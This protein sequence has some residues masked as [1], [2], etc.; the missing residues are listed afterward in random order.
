MK[1]RLAVILCVMLFAQCTT[2]RIQLIGPEIFTLEAGDKFI[3]PGVSTLDDQPKETIVSSNL[4]ANHP[5]DYEVRYTL[6]ENGKIGSFLTRTIHVVDT[7]APQITLI[8]D[9]ITNVCPHT[10][11][12]DEG[13]HAFDRVDGDLSDKISVSLDQDILTYAISDATGNASF[14]TRQLLYRDITAPLFTGSNELTIMEGAH[15]SLPKAQDRCEGDVSSKIIA[16]NSIDTKIPGNYTLTYTVQD[17][18]GNKSTFKQV[19]H[20]IKSRS[21][22]T[23]YLTFDDGP[24][25][26]TAGFLDILKEFNVKATFFVNNRTSY[27]S[28]VKRAYAEGHTIAMHSSSHYY[29][30]IYASEEAFYRDLYANQAWIKSLIGVTSNLYRFPGGSSNSVSSFNPGIMSSLTQS[31][32]SKGIQYFDWNLSSGD[33]SRNTSAFLVANVKRQLGTRSSYVILMHDGAGHSA[34]LGALR[35]II[36]YAS[37]LGYTFKP[38]SYT[39]PSAHHGVRN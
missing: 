5:G 24:S 12:R 30:G 37:G 27:A 34:T 29:Q 15:L 1:K 14:A 38:I 8:G 2:T 23:L 7:Q 9:K 35:E 19:V 6:L 3:D 22:T 13:A 26:L 4:D 20:V 16:E 28:L 32:R 25:S 21:A 17:S 39:S 36:T 10:T 18:V 31:I 33:G 11:Y